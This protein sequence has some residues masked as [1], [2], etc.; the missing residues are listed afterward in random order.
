MV[1]GNYLGQRKLHKNTMNRWVLVKSGQSTNNIILIAI[2]GELCDKRLDSSILAS[3]NLVA[4]ICKRV[5]SVAHKNHSQARNF[6][7]G[8]L[9]PPNLFG[10]S[11][12]YFIR[13]QLAINYKS[14]RRLVISC[15]CVFEITELIRDLISF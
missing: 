4:N 9:H 6:P 3:Y 1:G 2:L 11:E 15:A 10:N 13:N 8:I 14:S 7:N 12:P 5:P